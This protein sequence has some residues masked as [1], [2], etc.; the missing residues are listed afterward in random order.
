MTPETRPE[1]CGDSEP[2]AFGGR[3][4]PR[5]AEGEWCWRA[6]RLRSAAR[7]LPRSSS[8]DSGE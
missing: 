1:R 6:E 4:S 8:P 3:A 7:S 5:A 2:G